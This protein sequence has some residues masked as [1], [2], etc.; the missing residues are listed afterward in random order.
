MDVQQHLDLNQYIRILKYNKV[1]PKRIEFLKRE[2][3]EYTEHRLENISEELKI[4]LDFTNER[5][6]KKG[7]SM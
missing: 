3:I 6:E 4:F 1:S 7:K 2:Y 5:R